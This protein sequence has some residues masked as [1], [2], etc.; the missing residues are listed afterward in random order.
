M[1]ARLTIDNLEELQRFGHEKWRDVDL[2]AE[3]G[4]WQR[5]PCVTRRMTTPIR[6][7]RFVGEAEPPSASASC[8]RACE[9]GGNALEC[10]LC[11]DK[12]EIM[13]RGR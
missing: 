1:V 3:V 7:C 4:G 8:R 12:A 2:N 5:S 6:A 13:R 11:R 10:M 9:P